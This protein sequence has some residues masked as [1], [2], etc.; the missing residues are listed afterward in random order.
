MIKRG[1]ADRTE[2]D[3]AGFY[4]SVNGYLTETTHFFN[5]G[6]W[7]DNPTSQDDACRA[8]VRLVGLAAGLQARD[9]VLDAGIGYG[10]QLPLWVKDFEVGHV[11]GITLS[12]VQIVAAGRLCEQSG[13]LDRITLRR[14]S[15]T[16]LDYPDASFDKVVA[17]ES[18]HHF[19]T[20][21]SFFREARRVLMPG[22]GF[23]ACDILPMPR[24][25]AGDYGWAIDSMRRFPNPALMP[26]ANVVDR[27]VYHRQ[28]EEAGFVNVSVISIR[29]HV[30]APM[31]RH[32][33]LRMRAGQLHPL[34]PFRSVSPRM[35]LA[36][37]RLQYL[38]A[39]S[40]MLSAIASPLTWPRTLDACEHGP[41]DYVLAAAQVPE[42]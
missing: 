28:L 24:G 32:L 33:R 29:E 21:K 14:M 23:A 6:Y 30:Y 36:G 31:A 19:Q 13:I 37:G 12:Q 8:L 17:V 10:D 5:Q 26:S 42:V 11:T 39:L 40:Q 7:E 16:A 3:V 2:R 9:R 34:T 41:L 22:G 1:T 35:L 15:A 27:N 38:L 20:R 4:D 18:G 25:M